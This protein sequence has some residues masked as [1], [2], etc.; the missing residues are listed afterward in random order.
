M[1]RHSITYPKDIKET[2]DG[3]HIYGVWVRI[4]RMKRTTK[5]ADYIAFYEWSMA[6]GYQEGALLKLLDEAKPYG[7]DNCV[8]RPATTKDHICGEAA[9]K[10]IAEWNRTVNRIRVHY[11][12]KPFPVEVECDG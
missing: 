11:G 8:W 4:R 12:M 1:P 9:R 5:F 10:R 2:P 3:K 7:P 6:N